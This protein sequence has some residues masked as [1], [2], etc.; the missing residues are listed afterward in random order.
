MGAIGHVASL[1]ALGLV[2]LFVVFMVLAEVSPA[3]VA[4]PSAIVVAVAAVLALRGVRIERELR[5]RAGSPDLR[6][7]ANRQR[8]RRG[9]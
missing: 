3:E 8:E 7:A 6:E 5:S 9:F 4:L 1:L 2:V